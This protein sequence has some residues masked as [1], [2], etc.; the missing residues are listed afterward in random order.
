VQGEHTPNDEE[1]TMTLIRIEPAEMD[2]ATRVIGAEAETLGQA[3]TGLRGQSAQAGLPSAV[4]AQVDT[5]LA[6]LERSLTELRIELLL[7]AVILTM[8]GMLAL[9]GSAI[10]GQLVSGAVTTRTTSTVA[11]WT[12]T[13]F[14]SYGTPQEPSIAGWTGMGFSSYGT[15]QEPSIA[16]WTGTGFTAWSTDPRPRTGVMGIVPGGA[17]SGGSGGM[18]PL[19]LADIPTFESP[20]IKPESDEVLNAGRSMTRDKDGDGVIDGRDVNPFSYD[21]EYTPK[22]KEKNPGIKPSNH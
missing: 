15:P 13:G 10:A 20:F 4:A 12:G 6:T 3:I 22:F 1:R 2:T 11:G 21:P 18:K 7:E 17:G 9:K 14:S 16:G 19:G 8:R 5:S